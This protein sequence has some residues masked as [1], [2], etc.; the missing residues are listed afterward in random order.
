MQLFKLVDFPDGFHIAEPLNHL[1]ELRMIV[2]IGLP[3]IVAI[4]SACAYNKMTSYSLFFSP[5]MYLTIVCQLFKIANM[6]VYGNIFFAPIKI[7]IFVILVGFTIIKYKI[8]YDAFSDMICKVSYRL[9][10]NWNNLWKF[11]V[12]TYII[13][14]LVSFVFVKGLNASIEVSLIIPPL[15]INCVTA[16]LMI[17]TIQSC[18]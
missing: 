12:C 13:S 15:I 2:K 7:I 5:L 16:V 17:A 1:F 4:L 6:Y 9:E 10:K 18:K 11:T 8:T 3:I 14:I